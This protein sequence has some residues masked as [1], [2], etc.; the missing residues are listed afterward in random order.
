MEAKKISELIE[1]TGVTR[2]KVAESLGVS[3]AMLR[4]Y[5]HGYAP[6]PD[7]RRA[8]LEKL[9]GG[10]GV[11]SGSLGAGKSAAVVL[12][13]IPFSALVE[14]VARRTRTGQVKETGSSGKGARRP[15]RAVAFT[16]VTD[17]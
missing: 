6:M 8:I 5:E 10:A 17:A 3:V 16:D 9:A 13:D 14:E 11:S 12:A 7:A 2:Q 4:K 1:R 15:L